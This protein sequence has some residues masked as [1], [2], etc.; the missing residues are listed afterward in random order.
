MNRITEPLTGGAWQ[1]EVGGR[2]LTGHERFLMIK[3]VV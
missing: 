3:A 2:F 1:T